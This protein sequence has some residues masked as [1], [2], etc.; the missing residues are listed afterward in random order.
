MD[1]RERNKGQ[2]MDKRTQRDLWPCLY[3]K[4]TGE[5][6]G[7]G[8]AVDQG[9]SWQGDHG[10]KRGWKRFERFF[11]L[12]AVASRM[13]YSSFQQSEVFAFNRPQ[14]LL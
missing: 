7:L 1:E 9:K 5:G 14:R 8:P 11:M 12:L 4:E 3:H 10:P 2:I 6:I 13:C